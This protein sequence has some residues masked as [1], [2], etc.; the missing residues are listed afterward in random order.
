MQEYPESLIK[1]TIRVWKPYNNNTLSSTDAIEIVE[2]ILGFFNIL[3]DAD[4]QNNK[5]KGHSDNWFLNK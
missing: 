1:E 4:F 3:I 5:K 2:N